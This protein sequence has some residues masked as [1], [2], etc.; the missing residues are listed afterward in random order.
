M[1]LMFA[2]LAIAVLAG[3]GPNKE[4]KAETERQAAEAQRQAKVAELRKPVLGQLKDPASAKF[5]NEFFT[6]TGVLCG[7]VNSKNEYGAYVG[8]RKFLIVPGEYARLQELPM[9]VLKDSLQAKADIESLN[10]RLDEFNARKR[11]E[12]GLTS[13]GPSSL[14]QAYAKIIDKEWSARCLEEK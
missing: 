8:P 2:G 3:C 6:Q 5:E 4:E 12:L 9:I 14:E 11:K 13:E 1:R 10:A 7:T